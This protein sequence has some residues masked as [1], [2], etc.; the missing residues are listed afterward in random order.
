MTGIRASR[1]RRLHAVVALHR[2]S[3]SA[4]EDTADR[5]RHLARPAGTRP[6]TR[7]SWTDC[8]WRSTRSTRPAA[9]PASS[10]S[11]SIPA[12]TAPTT[13]RTR[14]S[15][16][17]LIDRG[18]QP[19]AASP[20]I[21]AWS[22]PGA[23]SSSTAQVPAI[24]TCSS[25]PTLPMTGHGFIFANAVTD[26]VQGAAQAEYAYEPG[27]SERLSAA[28]A[29]HRIHPDAALL[30]QRLQEARRHDRRRE[31]LRAA[32]SPTSRPR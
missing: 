10:R 3:P 14:S 12:T 21:R 29:G 31:H 24:S 8:W 17:S 7:R 20:A 16:R 6:T 18:R 2:A 15:P 1:L 32:A 13:R 5:R 19:D 30:R 26:N 23:R 28:L 4:D 11:R 22:T 9:S 25:S 27:L